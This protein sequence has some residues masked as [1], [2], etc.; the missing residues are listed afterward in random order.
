MTIHKDCADHLRVQYHAITGHK[1]LS[2]H[3]HE[4]V[5]AFFGYGSAAALRAE[6][7]RPLDRLIEAK[8]L[9]P[10][11]AMLDR[12]RADLTGY[13]H[14]LPGSDDTADL[15]S[16]YLVSSGNFSGEVW[17]TRDL[18]DHIQSDFIQ[19]NFPKVVDGLSGEIATTNAFFDELDLDEISVDRDDEG[20]TA[21]LNGHLNGETDQDRPFYGDSI[22]FDIV[23][24]FDLIS[25]RIGFAEPDF[26]ISG[27]VDEK[28]YYD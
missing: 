13:P 4:L 5:A 6:I 26:S 17:V 8:I 2:G 18:P 15:L 24:R 27:A 16:E 7:E 10:D 11:L 19:D 23:V 9:I 28:A 12:R 21:S 22:A 1:M 25:S 20:I 14:D 3:A